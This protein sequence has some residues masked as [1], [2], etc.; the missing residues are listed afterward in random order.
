TFPARG[1]NTRT[2]WGPRTG[3]L[4]RVRVLEGAFILDDDRGLVG[5]HGR[6]HFQGR[7]HDRLRHRADLSAL[8][9]ALV[10]TLIA[11]FITALVAVLVTLGQRHRGFAAL[12]G[13][14]RLDL[15][16]QRGRADGAAHATAGA[17]G[18]AAAAVTR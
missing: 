5:G 16:H 3:Q 11:A 13:T 15:L 12:R 6:S 8:V 7:R 4:H 17:A 9:T 1:S 10:A 2:R 18:A 14:D